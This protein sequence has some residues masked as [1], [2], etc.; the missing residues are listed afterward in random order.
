MGQ[1]LFFASLALIIQMVAL[2]PARGETFQLIDGGTIEGTLL[3][4]DAKDS[5]SY[6]IKLS[7][8][9]TI[10]IDAKLVKKVVKQRPEELEYK[11]VKGQYPD[12]A[13]GQFELAEWCRDK[14]LTE[15]RKKHLQRVIELEPDHAKARASLGYRRDNGEWKTRDQFMTQRGYVKDATG[16]WRLPQEIEMREQKRKDELSTK[17]WFG[18][19][20]RWHSWLENP[21]KEVQAVQELTKINDPYAVPAL[22]FYLENA[23]Y[24]PQKILYVECLSRI[25]G[26]AAITALMKRALEDEDSEVRYS[27]LDAINDEPQP[28][29]VKYFV[30]KLKSKD[31]K[32]VRRA[33]VGL[34]Q[35]NDKSAI[36]PLITALITTHKYKV[37]IGPDGYSSTFTNNGSGGGPGTFGF[38]KSTREISEDVQ[39]E[40]ALEALVALSEGMNFGYDENAWKTWWVRQKKGKELDARRDKG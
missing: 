21:E 32:M 1:R 27:C 14:K 2:R 38:G 37:Q 16:K 12:T 35:M 26:S 15:L 23:Q 4:A 11:Q 7:A 39:N 5:K 19:I 24:R 9:G 29:V 25:G 30:D 28:S 40:E 18:K 31:N 36:P 6:S 22:L 13:E 34:L 33:A 3:N 10:E 20:K 8:G 17:E